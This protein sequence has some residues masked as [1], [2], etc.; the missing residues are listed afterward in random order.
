ML[1]R[2]HRLWET[3]LVERL[4]FGWDEVHE[5]AEQLEH[6]TSEPLI[7]RLDQYL[8]HP[9]FDP[10][11]DPIPD[12][13]GKMKERHT[14]ALTSCSIG[15]QV[16]IAAVHDPNDALLHLLDQKGIGLGRQL[17]LRARHAFDGSLELKS[18]QGQTY[19]LSAQVAEHLQVELSRTW[20]TLP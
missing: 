20:G 11:G 18:K 1:F 8:G 9:R 13:N 15:D 14:R 3:F 17:E 10:H 4:G 6:V 19:V 2:S 7:E 16:R 12:K 5:V